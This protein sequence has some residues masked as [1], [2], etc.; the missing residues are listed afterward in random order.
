VQNTIHSGVSFNLDSRIIESCLPLFESGKIGCLEWS[1]DARDFQVESQNWFDE[2]LSLYGKENRLL[3][4]GIFFSIFSGKWLKEQEAW[5]SSLRNLSK[6]I[7]FSHISEHFGFMTGRDFHAGA[8]L[9]FP[10]NSSTLAIGYDRLMRIQ[11]AANCPVGLENLAFSFS[12]E[13]V[14][15]QGEF[16]SRLLESTNGFLILDLHNL[17]CQ[18]ANFDVSFQELIRFFPLNRVREIHISG[19]SWE[20]SEAEPGRMIRRDTHDDKVPE[21][22]FK[23]LESVL[24]VLPQLKFVVMEQITLGLK[25][26]EQMEDFQQDFYRM[27]GIVSDFQAR[28]SVRDHSPV[29]PFLP[30]HPL[31]SNTSPREDLVLFE[32]QQFLVTLLE[33]A[34]SVPALQETLNR[35]PLALSDWMIETWEDCMLETAMKIAQKWKDGMAG[36]DEM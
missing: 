6:N 14:K 19:G 28:N 11:E 27:K 18:S 31:P 23:F 15:R 26:S 36:L 1:F 29:H 21:E 25:T 3:G 24:P 4:H 35:S 5:L 8:P 32:Q 30:T 33:N 9:G 34:K 13:E 7:Q 20:K 17:Y 10:M 16:L 12:K 22:V 2:L